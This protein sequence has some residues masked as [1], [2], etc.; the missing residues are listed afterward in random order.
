MNKNPKIQKLGWKKESKQNQQ[1][2]K[3]NSMSQ[4]IKDDVINLIDNAKEMVIFSS[5]LLADDQIEEALLNAS[6]RHVRCYIMIAAEN[7]FLQTRDTEFDK[8]ALEHHVEMLESLKGHT[9]IRSSDKFHAKAIIADPDTKPNGFLLTA[10]LTEDALTRNQELFVQLEKDEILE[11]KDILRW[12][13]WMHSKH[14]HRDD[15]LVPCEKIQVDFP[16]R[17]KILSTTPDCKSIK[18]EI[19]KLL[20]TNPT[21][22]TMVSF[23][24]DENH[25]IVKK[26]CELSGKGSKITV[27]VRNREST[28]GAMKSMKE[29]GIS[30]LGYKWLHAKAILV[31]STTIIMSAN[32]EK[33]GMDDGFELGISLEDKRADSVRKK[34]EKWKELPEYE[35]C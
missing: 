20:N 15:Q 34:I 27:L 5:F 2:N 28:F 9:L 13:F 30:I 17:Q 18:D 32:I 23:G 6:K 12:A 24:W 22:V 14:E 10:N 7:R 21:N 19:M 8:K 35:F 25:E 11:C 16:T 33:N 1:K 31:D 4:T 26:L 29:A 3:S